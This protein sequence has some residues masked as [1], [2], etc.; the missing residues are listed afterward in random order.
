MIMFKKCDFI[1]HPKKEWGY[2]IVIE[3]QQGNQLK[4]SFPSVGIKTISLEHIQIKL[5]EC[6]N[7]I[8]SEL[9]D[10]I[11]KNRVYIDEPFS[12]I[13][14]DLKTKFNNYVVIIENGIYYEVLYEDAELMSRIYNWKIY[15]RSHGQPITGFKDEMT[16][17]FRD[18]RN[19]NISYVLVSQITHKTVDKIERKVSE[20][21][22]GNP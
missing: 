12:E 10:S 5:A 20:I 11:I 1:E 8:K 2:G 4:V 21:F 13:F 17:I 16:Y 15:E 22:H 18:L 9:I 3:N 6:S 14:Q 19:Q 7:E